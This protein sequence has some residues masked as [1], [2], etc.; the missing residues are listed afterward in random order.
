MKRKEGAFWVVQAGIIIGVLGLVAL[1]SSTQGGGPLVFASPVSAKGLQLDLTL[2]ATAMRF[3]GSITGRVTVVNKSDR[4]VTL[5][6]SVAQSQNLTTWI[7]YISVCGFWDFMGYA[8]FPGHFTAGN[9][10]SAGSPLQLAV[11]VVLYCGG[12]TDPTQVTFFPGASQTKANETDF[13]TISGL[14]PSRLNVTTI[15]SYRQQTCGCENPGL[16]GYYDTGSG[17]LVPFSPG[18]YTILAW[19]DWNQYV[20]VTFVVEPPR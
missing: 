11:P 9:I 6:V 12:P 2:N 10:S 4:N 1:P 18:E 13:G 7:S 5:S 20:Y 19:D 8:V 17:T 14:V 16:V 3:N 15:L